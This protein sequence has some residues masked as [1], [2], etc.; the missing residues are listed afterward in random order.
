MKR[1]FIFI[2]IIALM[3]VMSSSAM[4]QKAKVDEAAP[5][6]Q[7]M[8]NI[9]KEYQLS[10]YKGKYV[11]LEWINFDCPFVQ[12][13]YKSGN[14]QKLQKVYR[15]KD[16]IWFSVCSSAPG[17]QG[18]FEGEDLK[19]RMEKEKCNPTA[20]L[21]DADGKVGKLYGAKTTPHMFVINPEGI[22]IYA[23]GIDD[24]A[25]TK[26]EDVQ[27]ATNYVTAALDAA[28]QGET[29]KVKTATPYGCSVKYK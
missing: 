16:V 8:D 21:L 10:A 23:G 20:Y 19:E 28:M 14:M 4:A 7:L 6:F 26:L 25:S 24:K 11:V 12:K 9:G 5:D 1:L 3:S 18:Y 27:D 13:H 2:S 22:L 17:K 29:V 15:D